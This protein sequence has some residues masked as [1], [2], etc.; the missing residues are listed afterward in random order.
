MI[1]LRPVSG[2]KTLIL[3]VALVAASAV[4]LVAVELWPSPA[5]PHITWDKNNAFGI[6]PPANSNPA[7]WTFGAVPMCLDR[8]GKVTITSLTPLG[9]KDIRA[10]A[11]SVSEHWSTFG[12]SQRS[13]AAEGFPASAVVDAQCSTGVVNVMG[14]TF[15]RTGDGPGEFSSLQVNYDSAGHHLHLTIPWH[16]KLCASVAVVG[17]C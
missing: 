1:A 5:V 8:P 13:L 4:V 11:V 9:A 6:V 7:P 12:A 3:A 15:A 16:L 10:V 17:T 2:R 14:S